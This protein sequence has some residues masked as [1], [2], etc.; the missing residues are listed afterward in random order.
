LEAVLAL[1]DSERRLRIALADLTAELRLTRTDPAQLF[2]RLALTAEKL[3]DTARSHPPADPERYVREWRDLVGGVRSELSVRAFRSLCWEPDVAIQPE[4]LRYL[5]RHFGERVGSRAIQGLV[6]SCH[7]QWSQR[8]LERGGLVD[9]TKRCLE[10]FAGA[11]SVV[12]RWQE[13]WFLILD[14]EAP[15]HFAETLLENQA[16]IHEACRDW[17]VDETSRFMT[18]CVHSAADQARAAGGSAYDYLFAQ[19]LPWPGWPLEKYKAQISTT[20][21]TVPDT[22]S[23]RLKA[24]VV[25]DHR[26]GDPRLPQCSKNWIGIDGAA[27]TKFIQWL[28]RDD[29][30]FFFEHVL[31][32]GRDPH[33]RKQFWLQYVPRVRRSRPLLGWQDAVRLR[34]AVREDTQLGSFGSLAGISDT[35]AFLLDFG[36]LM[37]VEFSA[38]GNACFVYRRPVAEKIVPEFWCQT[39]L[40]IS[41]PMGLKQEKHA[42][43]RIRHV[44]GWR[45]QLANLLEGW[46]IRPARSG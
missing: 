10:G 28:S 45:T 41:G 43:A 39:P 30:V 6:R 46:G 31:P 36:D 13:R 35:S 4:F 29:I 23:S 2:Q 34:G 38:K 17:T 14:R 18:E 44:H 12:K 16:A 19:I 22:L 26:L 11:S 33:Y 25:S 3:G 42:L 21:L 9:Y 32:R 1:A 37:V 24:Y 7:A 15:D 5:E 40:Q 20:I 8:V 27:Q